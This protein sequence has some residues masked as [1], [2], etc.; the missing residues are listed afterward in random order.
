M[1]SG[2]LWS[3]LK[4]RL[5]DS[6]AA[7]C[8]VLRKWINASWIIS[9]LMLYVPIT[10]QI[11]TILRSWL[12]MHSD[13][14][15]YI[16]GICGVGHSSTTTTLF[17]FHATFMSLVD[18]VASPKLNYRPKKKKVWLKGLCQFWC[19]LKNFTQCQTD[20]VD[21]LW[22]INLCWLCLFKCHILLV[23]Q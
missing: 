4:P 13:L 6:T 11:S 5:P 7:A 12:L 10:M 15:G 18:F 3:R 22:K 14:F 16:W 21:N 1:K 19:W 23:L 9:E 2:K 17:F 20:L 8:F